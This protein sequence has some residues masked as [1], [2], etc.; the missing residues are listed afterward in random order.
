[1][2][3]IIENPNARLGIWLS[4]LLLLARNLPSNDKLPDVILLPEVKELA[5]LRRPLGAQSLRE[6]ILRQAR[7]PLFSLLNHH[8]TENRNVW[9]DDAP[10][11]RLALAFPCPTRAVARLSIA[12]EEAHTEGEE[13]TLFHWETLLIIATC[14]AEDVSLEF[15]PERVARD[16]LG[17]ALFVKDSAATDTVSI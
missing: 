12:K 17:D 9:A 6:D 11:N 1:M 7:D 3:T 2:M 16:F 4:A 10:P 13:D 8:Q 15:I 5:N 14:D